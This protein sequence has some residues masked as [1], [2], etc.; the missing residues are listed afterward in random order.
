MTVTRRF[1][2]TISSSFDWVICQLENHEA[3]VS[4][5]INEL[6]VA[7]RKAKSQLAKVKK[8]GTR[9][10]TRIVELRTASERWEERAKRVADKD[11][12]KALE[13]LKRRNSLRTEI[14]HLET[15]EREH[16]KLE[17]QLTQ[18][19]SQ[20]QG[21]IDE[22]KRKKN[23]FAARQTRQDVLR[24]QV[25]DNVGLIGELDDIFEKWDNKIALSEPIDFVDDQLETEFVANEEREALAHELE[26]LLNR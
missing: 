10:R 16:S 18:D 11:Q 15:Q 4:S 6:Q 26:E 1:F 22:L 7:G 5:A 24:S 13:C 3:L 20:M 14:S 2:T 9:L 25:T 21:R 12:D 17:A 8:D 23:Q 19:L